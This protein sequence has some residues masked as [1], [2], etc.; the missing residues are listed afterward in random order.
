MIVLLDLDQT[1][2]DTSRF[3]QLRRQR[4]W[5]EITSNMPGVLPYP[6]ITDLLAALRERSI[7]WGVVTSAPR[8]RYAVPLLKVLGVKPHVVIGYEDTE[9]RKPWPDPLLRAHTE[10]TR[11]IDPRPLPSSTIY[12]GDQLNDMIAARAAGMK[13]LAAIWLSRETE[14]DPSGDARPDAFLG[15]PLDLLHH[16]E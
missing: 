5:E 15:A 7:P 13:A 10:L 11:G 9:R 12:V 4:R 1:M 3:E 16:L 2:A 14:S 8:R 6:G